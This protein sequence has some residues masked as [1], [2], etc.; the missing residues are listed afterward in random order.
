MRFPLSPCIWKREMLVGGSL[1]YVLLNLGHD[2]EHK[3]EHHQLL[4]GVGWSRWMD[5][6]EFPLISV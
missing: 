1:G 2:M 3:S 5:S 4:C 6:G